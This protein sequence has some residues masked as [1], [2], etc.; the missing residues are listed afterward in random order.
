MFTVN[1]SPCETLRYDGSTLTVGAA[2]TACIVAIIAH[3]R[4]IVPVE[5]I[6]FDFVFIP[7]F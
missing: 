5:H 6:L 4:I 3:I 7:P 1:A 2:E